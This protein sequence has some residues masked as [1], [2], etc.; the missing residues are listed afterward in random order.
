MLAFLVISALYA[1]TWLEK[2]NDIAAVR[3]NISLFRGLSGLVNETQKERGLSNVFLITNDGAPMKA[4]RRN[5]DDALARVAA[6]R[7]AVALT[8]RQ[9]QEL[10]A[11]L[12]VFPEARRRTD[13]RA[14]S[15]E[16]M[17]IY[18]SIVDRLLGV[19]RTLPDL[20]D[21]GDGMRGA[22]ISMDILE[23]AKENAGLLRGTLAPLIAADRA[24]NASVVERLT[25]LKIRM[26][27][28]LNS[29]VL[30]L[31]EKS[32][33]ML[34]AL[35]ASGAWKEADDAIQEILH[36]ADTGSFGVNGDTFWKNITGVIDELNRIQDIEFQAF[37]T[38]MSQ[39]YDDASEALLAL[40]GV[41]AVVI[42]LISIAIV[43]VMLSITRPIRRL[44]TYADEVAGGRLDAPAPSDMRHE[45]GALCASLGVMIGNLR[46]MLTQSEQDSRRAQEESQRAQE[47]VRA[48]EEAKAA[49][50]RA[51]A[52]GMLDAAGKLEGIA[53]A[54]D[55]AMRSVREQVEHSEKGATDQAAR[56][57]ETA[58]AMERMN[59]SVLDVA[60][61]AGQAS[62][63]S[64]ATREKA[65]NGARLSRLAIESIQGV[66][67]QSLKLKEDM[68]RL[69]ANARDIIA[70]L[71]VITDIADQ[72]NLLALNAAIEAARAGEA[73]R[74][75]AV[76]ADEVRKLAEKTM[77]STGEVGR[78][79]TGIQTSTEESDKQMDLAVTAIEEAARLVNESGTAL[80]EIV[81]MADNSA[82]QVQAIAT[83]AESQSSASEDINQ[84]LADIDRISDDAVDAMQHS[85]RSVQDVSVQSGRLMQLIEEL[86]NA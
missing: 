3:A 52:E 86:K 34:R 49:A 74:G 67:E 47:A 12:A 44:I 68:G 53:A 16:V 80:T 77:A 29:D 24:L 82:A 54:I 36:K 39:T 1:F 45:L 5:A 43:T 7:S 69:S 21:I 57:A 66:R 71:G 33:G 6:L 56:I 75:F 58:R 15:A 50:E 46:T 63:V 51:K 19:A 62:E 41:I 72:T 84:S 70:V 48:S 73:G 31:T 8:A 17:G 14:S 59:A 10:D 38:R 28:D 61:N 37:E 83:A 85:A 13:E 30:T 42:A 65:E 78:T 9:N 18:S 81:E 26:E 55:D 64:A 76:V 60:R 32:R 2:K 35:R 4:Q 27:T 22:F 23:G 20:K 40:C 11:T 79:I 25:A